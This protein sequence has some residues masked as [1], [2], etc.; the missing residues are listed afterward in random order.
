ML[1]YIVFSC[2][3][4]RAF[5]QQRFLDAYSVRG[6]ASDHRGDQGAADTLRLKDPTASGESREE[7]PRAVSA[8]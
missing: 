1:L 2:D 7:V 8:M 3:S 5:A 6:S 4:T